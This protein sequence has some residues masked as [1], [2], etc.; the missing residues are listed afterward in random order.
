MTRRRAKRGEARA[1]LENLP[2]GVAECIEWPFSRMG[3]DY[4]TT[5][6][7][8]GGVWWNGTMDYAHR[9]SAQ[10]HLPP[11]PPGKNII[12]HRCDNPLCVNPVHLQ[13]G[14][15]VGNWRDRER[16][17]TNSWQGMGR[18]QHTKLDEFDVRII[19]ALTDTTTNLDLARMFGVSITN[20]SK[21]VNGHS[22][23]HVK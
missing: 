14:T 15:K 9:V 12:R 6:G 8:Y 16:T 7:Q 13:W 21:I 5:K 4:I 19:R 22:W 11:P 3:G 10:I 20:I 1:F 18:E 23:R 2:R 17:G